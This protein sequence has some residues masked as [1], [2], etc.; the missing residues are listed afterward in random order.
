MNQLFS[1][2]LSRRRFLSGG[3][4]VAAGFSLNPLNTLTAFTATSS[5]TSSAGDG[6]SAGRLR[7]FHLTAA[8]GEVEIGPEQRY[9]TW[10][11]NDTFPG[12]ALRAQEGER[13]RITVQNQIKEETTVHW[14][15][16]PVPNEA[17]GVP[18]LT[19][20]A[21]APGESFL[22]EFD[23]APAG[24]YMY[25][26]HVG[27]QL[28]RGLIGPLIIEERTPH[29]A[30]DREYTLILD[31]FLPEAPIIL[32]KLSAS[33]QRGGMMGGMMGGFVVPPYA[34]LLANGRLPLDQAT[35][36]VRQG[37][38]IRLRLLN[39]SGATT[40]QVAVDGHPMTV[41]HADG[42]PVSPVTVDSLL[43]SMGERYDVILEATTP[44]IWPI[45][46]ASIEGESPP[47]RALLRYRGSRAK[48]PPDD[49]LPDGLRAGRVLQLADLHSLAPLLPGSP[50]RVFDLVLS[51]RGESM[52]TINGETWPDAE[53][54]M[55]ERGERVR[56]RVTNH[57]MMIHPMHL[58]GHFFQ[59]GNV[60]KDTV[61]VPP[62][63]GYVELDFIT[64]N[65]GRW[66]FHCH[67]LYHMESGM[68]REV[69]YA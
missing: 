59:V 53:L 51:G 49:T 61:I 66:L 56:F 24:T 50:D 27:L 3:L 29:V 37:E 18:G 65:P 60:L 6:S 1:R 44:G 17:D 28:D 45:V 47:A 58:H 67:N 4:V 10:L 33:S 31:D 20:T 14:H 68:A 2:Q 9:R 41:T 48:T 13:L 35:F 40:F 25:H 39:L 32:E 30:Y 63:M 62:H 22:Y 21:I 54:L 23:A 15:G 34:G 43:I 11:Y 19:Q 16:I 26:S 36:E 5:P 52:W 12:P 69:R 55:V 8:E 46:A 42:Q 64:D 7:T 38:R 57:S